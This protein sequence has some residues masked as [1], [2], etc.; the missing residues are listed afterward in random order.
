[1]PNGTIEDVVNEVKYMYD[2]FHT[3]KGGLLLA[4]GNGIMGDTPLESIETMLTAMV[5]L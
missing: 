1:M 2:C 5:K 4:A 3:P